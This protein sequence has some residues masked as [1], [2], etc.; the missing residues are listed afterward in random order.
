MNTFSNKRS[1]GGADRN[2]LRQEALNWPQ[3]CQPEKLSYRAYRPHQNP[4]PL[5]GKLKPTR[6]ISA[7][8]P[9]S[10]T[11]SKMSEGKAKAQGD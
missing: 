7:G 11:T 2:H 3:K 5:E 8:T 10:A 9:R 6:A 4:T 1:W